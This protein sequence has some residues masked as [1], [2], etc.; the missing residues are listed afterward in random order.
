MDSQLRRR[1]TAM[2][3]LIFVLSCL[4]LAALFG[5]PVAKPAAKSTAITPAPAM[6]TPISIYG[7]W[8]CGSEFCSWA[9][10]RNMTDFDTRNRWIIDRGDGRPSVNLVVLSF[11]H[12]LR[13]LNKTK[14]RKSTRLNSSHA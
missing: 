6:A 13:L 3:K 2:R 10:V 12:P 4:I 14:D 7:A 1:K 5:G 11:V 9:S 8:H